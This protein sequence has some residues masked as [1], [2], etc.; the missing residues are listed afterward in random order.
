MLIAPATHEIRTWTTDSRRWNHFKPRPGD[1]VIATPAK[2]GTT[3]MQQIVSLLVFASPEPRPVQQMAPWL[4]ARVFGE[5]ED[6]LAR[7]EAQT[8]RR[9]IKSHLPLDV[10]PFYDEVKYINVA[11]HGL[12]A[13]MSWVNHAHSTKEEALKRYDAA[14]LADELVARPYPRVPRDVR[15]FF[16][17]WISADIS[18]AAAIAN[19]ATQYFWTERSFWKERHAPN[20]LMVH[21]NDL[22][23]DLEGEMRRIADFLDIAIPGGIWST[24]VDAARFESMKNHGDEVLAGA[25]ATFEGGHKSFLFK[26]ENGRWRDVLTKDDIARYETRLK[27]ETSPALARWLETGRLVAGDPRTSPD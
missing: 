1:I 5:L 23:S 10:L 12:D 26:G 20:L 22:K 8:H 13:F 15:E 21:Y 2:C 9:F 18:G 3:W 19:P 17:C 14:G 25:G 16:N 6:I 7:L 11:R 4:D 27:E 24:L